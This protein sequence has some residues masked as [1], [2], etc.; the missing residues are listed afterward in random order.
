MLQGAF[1]A[2][3]NKQLEVVRFA[4]EQMGLDASAHN[5]RGHSLLQVAA[6]QRSLDIAEYLVERGA[7]ELGTE[8]IKTAVMH[9]WAK[10]VPKL[11]AV[12][13]FDANC[14]DG[15]GRSLLEIA[16]TNQ[17][18]EVFNALLLGYCTLHL[19][20]AIMTATGLGWSQ[21]VELAVSVAGFQVDFQQGDGRTLLHVAA[22]KGHA[23]IVRWLVDAGA[24][25]DTVDNAGNKA[26]DLV[27][28][29]KPFIRH[30]LGA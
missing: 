29:S 12:P 16:V 10:V 3:N 15:S 20:Q 25:K 21:A 18:R 26:V 22:A 17:H 4:I 27:D 5:E 11:L 1:D 9:G 8:V 24:N 30:L 19:E 28:P 2:V 13:G 23:D 14:L 6:E 7:I